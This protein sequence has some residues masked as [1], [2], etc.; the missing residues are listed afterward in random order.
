MMSYKLQF[1]TLS[2]LV[3]ALLLSACA[4]KSPSAGVSTSTPGAPNAESVPAFTKPTDIT[5]PF[6]PVSSISQTLSLGSEGGKGSRQELTL[7]PGLKTISWA[8]GNTQVRVVQFVA[9]SAGKLDEVAYDYLAQADNGDVYYMGEDVANYKDGQ[10][11]SREGSWLAGKDGA[12]PALLMPARPNTGMVFHPENLPGVAYETDEVLGM[13]E[14]TTTPKGPVSDGLLIKETLMDN[15]IEYK[16]W[17]KG[18]GVVEDRSSDGKVML[19]LCNRAD[20]APRAIPGSL[21]DIEAQAE[22]IFDALSGENW[23]EAKKAVAAIGAAWQTY[24]AQAARDGAPQPFQDALSAAF[25]RLQKAASANSA[26]GALQ[27]ANDLSAATIDLYSVYQPAVPPDLGRLDMLERQIVLDVA[28]SDLAAAANT[29][30]IVDAIWA[31]L[32]PLMLLHNGS[33]LAA[34]FDA[35]LAAQRTAWEGKKG[36]AVTEQAQ[37]ALELVDA[38]E[39]LY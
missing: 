9:Y 32:K 15:S 25:D 21:Q 35:S 6:F 2:T 10:V 5:N 39:K 18:F 20:A 13:N 38:L 36:S 37:K 1:A 8:G 3:V 29:L 7:L 30:A 22:T 12:P 34:Q 27:A 23:A 16:V 4:G 14:K 33:E 31:R 24:Q 19:V 11:A 28:A 17:V 26:S